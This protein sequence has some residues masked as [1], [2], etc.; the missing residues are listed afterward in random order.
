MKLH[1][2]Y[3]TLAEWNSP[4]TT[5]DWLRNMATRRVINFGKWWMVIFVAAAIGSVIRFF[6][7]TFGQ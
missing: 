1:K 6:F 5:G 4:P 7:P 2:P 3:T